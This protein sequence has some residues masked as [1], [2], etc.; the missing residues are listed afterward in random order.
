[1]PNSNNN[2]SEASPN[3][4]KPHSILSEILGWIIPIAITLVIAFLLRTFVLINANVPTGSMLNTIQLDDNLF[5]LR[6]A[7]QFSEPQRGDIVIFYAPDHPD[8][9]Y[10]KRIIGEP[11]DKV[12]ISDSQI[13]INNSAEPLEEDYLPE[14]WVVDNDGYEFSVPQD[15]YLMLGDNRNDSEDARDW[16]NT[17]VSRDAIIAKAWFIYYPFNH[18]KNLWN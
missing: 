15:S 2:S 16:D 7:Y 17:Y 5:G 18:I 4:A 14:E 3:S 13:Y 8:T 12:V 6:I 10:I 1:M 9:K 11:G